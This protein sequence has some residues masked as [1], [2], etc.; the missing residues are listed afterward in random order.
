MNE[1]R[2]L[3]CCDANANSGFGHF[4]RCLNL[5]RELRMADANAQ[6]VF[7]GDFADFA[8]K[9]LEQYHFKYNTG[10]LNPQ[11]VADF[12]TTA[13]SFSHVLVDS[14]NLNQEFIDKAVAAPFKFILIDDF[15]AHQDYSKV[16]LL[17]NFTIAAESL[18]YNAK[19]LALGTRYFPV[20]PEL[21][22]VR[23]LKLKSNQ[24]DLKKLAISLSGMPD[25]HPLEKQILEIC[26]KVLSNCMITLLSSRNDVLQIDSQHQNEF[27]QLQAGAAMEEI[28]QN[29]DFI[30]SGGGLVKYEAAFCGIPNA[31][32]SLSDGVQRDT[33]LFVQQNLTYDLG[34]AKYFNEAACSAS[35]VNAFQHKQLSAFKDGTLRNFNTAASSHLIQLLLT[36]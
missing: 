16:D 36:C 11:N 27:V 18:G 22:E 26:N 25:F 14:Y 34:Q 31:T 17:I 2:M 28:Y 3:F 7:H 29:N 21:K 9:L 1:M 8:K 33:D 19:N 6:I 15:H 12:L 10:L 30:I 24:Y 32:I 20:K 13:T 23:E 35:L 4:S 5:A